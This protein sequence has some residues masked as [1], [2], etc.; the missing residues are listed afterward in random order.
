MHEPLIQYINAIATTPLTEKEI[1]IIKNI[2]TPRR[3]RKLQFF[4]TRG[5]CMQVYEFHRKGC[6]VSYLAITKENA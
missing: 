3:I 4:F 5:G 2:F 1:N 6:H